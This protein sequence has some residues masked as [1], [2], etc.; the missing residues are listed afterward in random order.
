M[1]KNL[2]RLSFSPF[3]KVLIDRHPNRGFPE[4]GNWKEEVISIQRSQAR[5]CRLDVPGLFRE[6]DGAGCG[7]L[8]GTPGILLSGQACLHPQGDVLCPAAYL[9]FLHS[10]L[11]HAGGR[12]MDLS[13][14]LDSGHVV[15]HQP[16]D[17]DLQY[18]H[19]FLPGKGK[20]L[21]F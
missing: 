21:L 19:D 3:G 10:A 20:R 6:H 18:I 2:N 13:G 5:V 15:Q 8:P 16:A 12:Q 14:G 9:R 17:D 7:P 4:G 1:V 11:L